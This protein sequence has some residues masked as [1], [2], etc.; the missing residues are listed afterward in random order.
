MFSS[1]MHMKSLRSAAFEQSCMTQLSFENVIRTMKCILCTSY[2]YAKI[3]HY[4]FLK[5]N[6]YLK[7]LCEKSANCFTWEK[8]FNN[9]L[10]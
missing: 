10:T 9:C 3:K 7:D 8:Y 4:F 1:F 5:L 6:N 2:C